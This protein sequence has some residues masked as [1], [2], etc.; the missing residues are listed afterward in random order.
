MWQSELEQLPRQRALHNLHI[1][2][3]HLGIRSVTDD[4]NTQLSHIAYPTPF[5]IIS[6]DGASDSHRITHLNPTKQTPFK[7]IVRNKLP[8]LHV[9]LFQS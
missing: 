3:A 1:M 9:K 7:A 2:C 5:S 8:A 6:G 4:V